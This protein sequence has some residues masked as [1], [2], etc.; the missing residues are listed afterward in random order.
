MN[1]EAQEPVTAGGTKGGRPSLL[2]QVKLADGRLAWPV[3]SALGMSEATFRSRL[4]LGLSPDRATFEPVRTRQE[5][6]RKAG[7]APRQRYG[8]LSGL[9]LLTL[10]D[11]RSALEAAAEVGVSAQMLRLR[12]SRGWPLHRAVSQRARGWPVRKTR[13][14]AGVASSRRAVRS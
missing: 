9:A 10:P 6:G 3:A 4:K 12:L 11:G 13:A 7:R 8:R 2:D 14:V 5:V 1:N